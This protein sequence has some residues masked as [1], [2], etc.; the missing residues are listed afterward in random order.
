MFSLFVLRAS[1]RPFLR[2]ESVFS[3][4]AFRIRAYQYRIA[5]NSFSAEASIHS[6]LK[7]APSIIC[8]GM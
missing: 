2:R 6:S 4:N 5:A 1:Y 7:V 8:L 3:L